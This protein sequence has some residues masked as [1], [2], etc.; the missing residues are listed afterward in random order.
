AAAQDTHCVFHIIYCCVHPADGCGA[1]A[2]GRKVCDRSDLQ[3]LRGGAKEGLRRQSGGQRDMAKDGGD[4]GSNGRG[5]QTSS[6]KTQFDELGAVNW[7]E[8]VPKDQ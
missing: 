5:G 6:G 8:G 1:T 7:R 2:E 3:I 4:E